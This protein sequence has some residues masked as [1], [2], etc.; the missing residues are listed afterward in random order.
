MYQA[1]KSNQWRRG[2]KAHLGMDAVPG[3]SHALVSTAANI[4]SVTLAG[5]LLHSDDVRAIGDAGSRAVDKREEAQGPQWH[6][7]M[8]AGERNQ[9][10]DSPLGEACEKAGKSKATIR[11]KVEHSFHMIES[12]LGQGSTRYRR[13]A[14]NHAQLFSLFG[15]ANLLIA[16]GSYW[17]FM[18]KVRLG[19]V[20]NGPESREQ[21]RPI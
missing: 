6:V 17:R 4:N 20:R 7:A 12:P 5:E 1:K 13:L 10:N 8:Q 16:R 18:T 21:R 15:L 14:S 11:A 2:M 19:S 3:L 9:F